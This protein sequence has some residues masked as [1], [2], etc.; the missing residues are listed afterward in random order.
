MQKVDVGVHCGHR[1]HSDL[2]PGKH[3]KGEMFVIHTWVYEVLGPPPQT[4]PI[5]GLGD[6]EG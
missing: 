4:V 5:P 3:P 2:Y 6:E 1:G